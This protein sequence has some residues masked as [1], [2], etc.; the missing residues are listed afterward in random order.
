LTP[1]I[2]VS[3]PKIDPK[4]VQE[5]RW[6]RRPTERRTEILEAALDAFAES[7][8]AGTRV[9]DIAERAGVSKGTVYLYFAGKEELFREAIRDKVARTLEKLASAAEGNHPPQQLARFIEAYWAHLRQ[10]HFASMYRLVM[11]ELHQFPELVRFYS[12]EISGKVIGFLAGLVSAGVA[13]GHFRRV[14]ASATSRIIVSLLVQHAV[15]T[16]RRELFSHLDDRTDDML[17][18]EIEDFIWNAL[19]APGV[20]RP[21]AGAPGA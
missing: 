19:L 15:W 7:G 6:R 5:P 13:S 20:A 16:S 3:A 2:P 10:P 8:L 14:D 18:G 4:A 11:A 9:E 12:Q 1:E 17:V 21:V